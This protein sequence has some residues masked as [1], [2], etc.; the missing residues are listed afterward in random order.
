MIRTDNGVQVYARSTTDISALPAGGIGAG[1][2]FFPSVPAN[3]ATAPAEVR[4]RKDSAG[5]TSG[6]ALLLNNLGLFWDGMNERPRILETFWL[7]P[8]GGG[9]VT[10]DSN[11]ILSRGGPATV[12]G[13]LTLPNQINYANNVYFP[14]TA[15]NRCPPGQAFCPAGEITGANNPLNTPGDWRTPTG[16]LHDFYSVSRFHEDGD[17]DAGTAQSVPYPGNKGYRDF[18]H[19]S[20]AS[21]NLAAW[22]TQDTINIAGWATSGEHNKIRRG[23]VAYGMPTTAASVPTTGTANYTSATGGLGGIAFGWYSPNG[24]TDPTAFRATVTVAVNHTTRAVTVT[25]SDARDVANPQGPAIA[26]LAT[27]FT[28]ALGAVGSA[29]TNFFA[30]ATIVNAT[31]PTGQLSGRLFGPVVTSGFPIVTTGASEIGGAFRLSNANNGA[32]I[33]GFIARKQ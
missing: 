14:R 11:S 16:T 6:A 20:Y 27:T 1:L 23:L 18:E 29:D 5:V 28:T 26:A 30:G 32:V 25:V 10:I 3:G 24:V 12:F 33:G 19:Y 17:V 15:P 22:V 31:L 8:N 2:G 13:A 9:R 4:F 7:A 21:S